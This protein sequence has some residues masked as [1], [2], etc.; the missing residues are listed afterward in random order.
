[1][2]FL[3]GAVDLRVNKSLIPLCSVIVTKCKKMQ[4]LYR[5]YLF[6]LINYDFYNYLNMNFGEHFENQGG[7]GDAN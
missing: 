5:E 7:G 1:M 4:N 3:H 6:I 2:I